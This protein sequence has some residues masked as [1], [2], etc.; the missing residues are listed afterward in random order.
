MT[1]SLSQLDNKTS[2]ALSLYQKERSILQVN[3]NN[4]D[5]VGNDD[6]YGKLGNYT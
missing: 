4:T 5:D 3:I 2:E 6:N 1:N